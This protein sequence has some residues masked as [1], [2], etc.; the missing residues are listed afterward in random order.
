[1]RWKLL[2]FYIAVLG[3]LHFMA[4]PLMTR[5]F[6]MASAR[7]AQNRITVKKISV[8]MLTGQASAQNLRLVLGDDQSAPLADIRSLIVDWGSWPMLSKRCVLEEISVAGA[9]L[10]IPFQESLLLSLGSML[11]AK[12]LPPDQERRTKE[13]AFSLEQK[14]GGILVH[15][16]PTRPS[17]EIRDV[18]LSGLALHVLTANVDRPPLPALTNCNIKILNASAWLRPDGKPTEFSLE[19]KLEGQEA[20]YVKAQ[21]SVRR[22]VNGVCGSCDLHLEGLD[23]AALWPWINPSWMPEDFS[24]FRVTQGLLNITSHIQITDN[25]WYFQNDVT[26][27]QLQVAV[28]SGSQPRKIRGASAELVAKAI[29]TLGDARIQFNNYQDWKTQFE[30][31]VMRGVRNLIRRSITEMIYGK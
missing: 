18:Y 8:D 5:G 12:M 24:Q 31:N 1:M 9:T 20:S 28:D 11:L 29:N 10:N 6:N 2:L 17:L 26:L 23:L 16:P 25:V 4:S 14:S 30:E 15:Y 19:T 3:A 21:G 27:K 7:F 13:P 22:T